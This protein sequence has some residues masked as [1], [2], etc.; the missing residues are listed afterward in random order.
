MISVL[1]ETRD[2]EAEL[3]R[4]LASLVPGAVE[5]VV[6]EVIVCD[7][8]ST[9]GTALVADHAGC[10]FLANAL[11]AGEVRTA[12]GDWLL[13]L[14]PGARLVSGWVEPVREHITVSAVPACFSRSPQT[15]LSLWSRLF[16]KRH[17]FTE[18]L[19]VPKSAFG[20]PHKPLRLRAEIH[21]A[22]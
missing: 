15:A 12:R 19:L 4:T 20:K 3:A 11:A 13:F 9:D 8:G 17:E 10:V 1:I 18:G 5:G 16:A 2:D 21:A 6:R 22:S 14:Q 7:R